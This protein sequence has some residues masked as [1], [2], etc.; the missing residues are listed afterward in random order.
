MKER[1]LQKAVID[2][3]RTWGYRVCHFTAAQARAGKFVTPVVADGAGFPDLIIVG[4]GRLIFAEMKAQRG[5]LRPTQLEWQQALLQVP[6][7]EHYVWKPEDWNS[8]AIAEVLQ[9]RGRSP[10][11]AGGS[12]PD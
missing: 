6:G 10:A 9:A 8:G 12:S 3:A 2:L 1:E 11:P 4:H 5:R 7:I